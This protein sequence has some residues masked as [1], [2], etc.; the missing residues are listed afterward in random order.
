MCQP[1]GNGGL[2]VRD[3][4]VVNLS[5]LV[6]WRWRMMQKGC[7]MWKEVLREKY[8]WDEGAPL[9]AG[10]LVCSTYA[11]RRWKDI[12]NLDDGGGVN[13]FNTEV[14]RR[15]GNGR[16]TSFGN[17]VW[18]GE[19]SF[20][21]RYPRLYSLS[22]QKEAFVGDCWESAAREVVGSLVGEGSFLF[23]R[24]LFWMFLWRN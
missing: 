7:L 21:E 22:N 3:I 18:R 11:S 23:G 8:G 4:K 24:L 10:G 17:A 13:W 16:E 5:L 2:G 14:I 20:R 19:R 9:G 12:A 1:K 6:K 15:V